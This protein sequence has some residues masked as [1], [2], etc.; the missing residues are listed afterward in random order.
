M[1]TVLTGRQM[2]D[3]DRQMTEKMGIPSEL[4]MERAALA[5]TEELKKHYPSARKIG[6][7]SGL[8]NN[9]ADGI[10]AA[11]ILA[12]EGFDCR[13][14]IYGNIE[15]KKGTGLV[16]LQYQMAKNVGVTF[17]EEMAGLSACDV[18]LDAVFGTGLSRPVEG[19]LIN[20]FHAFQDLKLPIIA[21]DIPSGVSSSDGRVLGTGIRADLTVTFAYLKAGL[22]L[23]PGKDYCGEVVLR[24]VGI[25]RPIEEDQKAGRKVLEDSDLDE[26]K[27][28]RFAGSNKGS[29]GHVLVIAGSYCMAGAACF[30]AKAALLSGAG[31]VKV[32]TDERNREIIQSQVP[33][34]LLSVYGTRLNKQ[35]IERNLS[36]ADVVLIGPGLGQNSLSR[37][38]FRLVMEEIQTPMVMDADALNLLSEDVSLLQ[39]PHLD[40]VITPHIAEMARLKKVS[41]SYVSEHMIS[42]AEEFANDYQ[43]TVVL[44][45]AAS[46]T[47]VPFSNTYINRTGNNGMSTGG[48][49]DVLAGLISGLMAQH[50]PSEKAAPLAVYLHGKAGDLARE[51]FGVYAMGPVEILGEIHEVLA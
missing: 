25:R 21:V 32:L 39:R 19:D 20:A 37:Q 29:Y 12:L 23:F 48:S 38:I 41:P 36:W 15:E 51:K 49:G 8:G 6:V 10:A 16:Y 2:Q 11:R 28:R 26:F 7:F 9:G 18:V 5:V 50:L 45:N 31:L 14:Y 43:V 4:L 22:L 27:P 3:A 34:A 24:N 40:L 30:S 47:A 33:E 42:L 1:L 46:V 35:E 17:V 13:V 44:K